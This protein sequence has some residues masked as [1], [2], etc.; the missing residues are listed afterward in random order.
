[1]EWLTDFKANSTITYIVS[2]FHVGAEGCRKDAI[3]KMIATAKKE[4]AHILILGD[5]GEAT[6]A[7]NKYFEFDSTDKEFIGNNMIGKQYRWIKNALKPV[8][9]Q[10]IGILTGNHDDRIAKV[11]QHDEVEELCEDLGTTYLK[12][13]AMIT[14][15]FERRHKTCSYDIFCVHGSG[16]TRSE[17]AA[18]NKIKTAMI[19][20]DA[21]LYASGHSHY[22]TE[23]S[24]TRQ[25]TTKFKKPGVKTIHFVNTGSFLDGHQP[26]KRSYAEKM[27]L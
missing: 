14:M 4:E 23:S 21:D 10:I 15:S 7:S 17:G 5:L 3:L 2:D 19:G 9:T 22:L 24:L 20:R 12:D 25:F 16:S 6:S 1:M 26:G 18:I 27:G 8:S 11:S 13:M